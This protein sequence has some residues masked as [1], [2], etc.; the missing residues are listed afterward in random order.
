M[1]RLQEFVDA[2]RS[3]SKP[4]VPSRRELTLLVST[5]AGTVDRLEED[6]LRLRDRLHKDGVSPEF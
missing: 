1:G 3:T 2:Y 6:L 5:L 4:R